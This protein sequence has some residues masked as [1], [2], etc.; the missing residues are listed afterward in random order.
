M[1]RRS[2]VLAAAILGV[3]ASQAQILER[4]TTNSG[5]NRIFQY[6]IQSTYG[7][8]TSADATPNLRVEAEAVLLKLDQARICASSGSACTTGSIEPSHVL[9]AMNV[10]R[11]LA[12]SSLR[13]SFG[14]E[15]TAEE[16]LY[17]EQSLPPIIHSLREAG[18]PLHSLS[19]S[20]EIADKTN[21]V[22]A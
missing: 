15:N 2:L 13:F 14:I 22:S 12:K 10:R 8:Q 17:L 11:D 20:E 3:S 18:T 1:L 9:T 19:P 16:I 5:T 21:P 4:T 6:S 7:T